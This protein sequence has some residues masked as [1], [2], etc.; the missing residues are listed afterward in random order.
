MWFIAPPYSR[1]TVDSVEASETRAVIVG[2]DVRNNPV[3]D[4]P[5]PAPDAGRWRVTVVDLPVAQSG[6]THVS[7]ADTGTVPSRAHDVAITPNGAKAIVTTRLDTLVFDLTVPMHAVAPIPYVTAAD[8]LQYAPN[9]SNAAFVSDSVAT[10]DT[11]AVVIGRALPA[12]TFAANVAV[13]DLLA[14]PGPAAITTFTFP[15]GGFWWLPTDVAINGVGQYVLIRMV[16]LSTTSNNSRGRLVA[17][18][19]STSQVTLDVQSAAPLN[20]STLGMAQGFD[21]LECSFTRVFTAGE[22]F[23]TAFAQIAWTQVLS[24]Q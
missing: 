20:P 6:Y 1:T 16:D 21:Q 19:L 7:F 24:F 4:P 15:D 12:S 17:I 23:N 11:K 22:R 13:I 8:P 2:K 9:T 5:P 3:Q 14:S 10:T 18:D